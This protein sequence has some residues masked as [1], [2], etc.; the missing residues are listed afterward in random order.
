[1]NRHKVFPVTSASAT[2]IHREKTE[3]SSRGRRPHTA[4]SFQHLEG[5]IDIVVTDE[6]LHAAF[7]FDRAAMEPI[8]KA[9]GPFERIFALCSF[10]YP[11]SQ[12]EFF[13][14]N[15]QHARRL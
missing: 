1:M 7:L 14:W 6:N 11:Q 2:D 13:Q 3:V 4:S 8:A 12:G 9:P 15:G 10:R 5:L